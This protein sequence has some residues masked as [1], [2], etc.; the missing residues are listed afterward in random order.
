M[1]T[2]NIFKALPLICSIGLLSCS[3]YR[4]PESFQDKMARFNPKSKYT[5]TIPD[6]EINE[7]L[8]SG[9]KMASIKRKKKKKTFSPFSNK[10]LYFLTLFQQYN[11]L[12]TFSKKETS[13]ISICP[14]FHTAFL[15]NKNRYKQQGTI[16]TNFSYSS[17]LGEKELLNFPEMFLPL[18]KEDKTP[19]VVDLYLKDRSKNLNGIV[20]EAL[21]IHLGKTFKELTELCEYGS[22]DNYYAYENLATHLKSKGTFPASKS[23]LKIL[24]KTTLFSN[25]AL[26]KSFSK[27]KGRGIASAKPDLQGTFFENV[28]NRLDVDWAVD[29][30][31]SYQEK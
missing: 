17:N 6:I 25:K 29:Y 23:N 31:N 27:T 26:I 15:D 24:F 9:R 2:S 16:R 14:N 7:S 28:V 18:S 21:D 30:L 11:K 1:N 8:F 20:Q 22:S 13:K 12:R 19:R 3:S 4:A 10:R 5:N